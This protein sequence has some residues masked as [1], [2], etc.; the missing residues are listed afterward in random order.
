MR[1]EDVDEFVSYVKDNLVGDEKGQAQLFCDRL[2]R[3]FGH[4]GIFEADGN[5]EVRVK[6]SETEK[7][8]FIDCLWSPAGKDGVLIEMKRKDIKNLESHFPQA[9]D[10]WMN[11]VPSRDIGPGCRKPRYIVLCNFDKFIIYD[12]FNKVDEVTLDE[13]PERYTCLS[14][15]EGK[16]PLFKNNTEDIS[17]DAARLIGELYQYLTIDKQ[18]DK[19]RTQHFIL[20]CVL[21]LFSEDVEL[22]PKGFFTQIIQ[23]CLDGKCDAYDEIGNLFR[24]MANPVPARAGKLKDIRYFNGGLFKEIDP[25]IL[26]QHCLEVLKEVADKDWTKV[27]PSIFG[28]LFEG[29]MRSK[30]RHKFGAHFTS[31]VDMLR[32]I[33]PTI[34]RPWKEK[35]AKADTIEKL[36][37][38][39][40]QMGEYRVLDPA[41]GCGNFL[42][43]AYREMKELEC[44]VID[45]LFEFPSHQRRNFN[46]NFPSVIKTSQFFGIDVQP[47]AVEVAKMTMMIAKELCNRTYLKRISA[48][49]SS[50]D[51]D[52]SLPLE[53]MD[54]NI[55]LQ[56]ALFS[57][58]PAFDVVVGN[59]PFQSK[60]KMIEE[61]GAAYVDKVKRAYPDV[62]GRADFCVYWL[63]KTH[64][65]MKEGQYAG[66]V[67]TNTIRQN[68]SRM[69]GLDYIVEEGG[70]ILDSVSTEVW[71]G[72]AAVYVSIA[73]WK[74]GEEKRK[75]VLSI[76]VGDSIDSPFEDY[77]LDHINSALSLFDATKAYVL[78]INRRSGACYQGQTHGNKYFLL[79]KEQAKKFLADKKN[80]DVIHPYLIGEELLGQMHSQPQRYVIDFRKAKDVFEVASYK[81][82]YNHIHEFVY[83]LFK[84]KADDEVKRNE[85]AKKINPEYK[86][87]KDHQSAFKTWYKLFRS[88]N[89]LMDHIE[90]IDRYIACSCV[91][92]RPI[93]EFISSKIHP[94]AALQVFPLDDDYSFGILQSVVHWEWFV[95]RCSTLK[96]DWRYTSDTV[97]DSFPW[98]Q[99]PTKKQIE[100]VAKQAK[101]L[102]DKRNEFMEERQLTLRQLY[103]IMDDTPNNPVSEIQNKLDN[104]VRDAYGMRHDVDI[105]Q[106]LLELN[107]KLYQKEQNDEIIQGPGLPN[108]IKD[109]S[110]LVSEDCVKMI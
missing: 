41:C 65:L 12:E 83:P 81:D 93:F 80:E 90:D 5:L 1:K 104:A 70:T 30:E 28:A 4:K 39:R 62:P 101:A 54:N 77:E 2:F 60:N 7:T 58:W 94:N 34:I 16:A 32:V 97:F 49:G 47:I 43:V 8:K 85:D 92:K 26:D 88:R 25:V 66:L 91:T 71:S 55:L 79:T 67:G 27:N 19:E 46:F 18:E 69:G 38:V 109:K 56:D 106:F 17:K 64:T 20:Q 84:K 110:E 72:D 82:L 44:Q 40:R 11:L 76:Q 73:T 37:E 86:E 74:K 102:R 51:F 35:I 98:P 53:N 42:F 24:Q 29:T 50:L 31:E 48:Y 21:A 33:T 9:R 99:N 107:G 6:E 3:A 14:F 87:K 103:R 100:E 15:L 57:E 96:G 63:R 45:K 13:L 36:N 108:K 78:Q 89:E 61:L 68:Y 23:D 10:Y 95:A 52:E 59:P 22:L 75:K 105:L